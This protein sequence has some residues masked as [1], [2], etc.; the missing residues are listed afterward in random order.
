MVVLC[1]LHPNFVD[2]VTLPRNAAAPLMSLFENPE[3]KK[4][5]FWRHNEVLARSWGPRWGFSVPQLAQSLKWETWFSWTQKTQQDDLTWELRAERGFDII[6][7]RLSVWR[8]IP[9]SPTFKSLN[10]DRAEKWRFV[11]SSTASLD[12]VPATTFICFSSW[13]SASHRPFVW[14]CRFYT[15]IKTIKE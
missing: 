2:L 9:V 11:N 14:N 4:R 8:P 5:M 7:P 1:L 13:L 12:R 10:W 6:F 15:I 3:F